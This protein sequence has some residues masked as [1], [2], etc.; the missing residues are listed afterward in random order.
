MGRCFLR[1]AVIGLTCLGCFHAPEI[2]VVD[3]ATALEQQAAGSFDEIERELERAAFAPVPVPLTPLQLETLGIKPV[4]FENATE[5]TEADRVEGLLRQHCIGEGSEGLL[6]DTHDAC[7]GASDR[8][9]ALAL[10][11]RVNQTRGGLWRWM[12]EQR[13]GTSEQEVRS[14]WRRLHLRGLVCGGWTQGDTGLW[15]GKKC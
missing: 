14:A 15:E 8:T 5:M 1:S 6:V 11:E 12:Q 4:P 2:V 7:K 10:M 3:R 13:P 9:L